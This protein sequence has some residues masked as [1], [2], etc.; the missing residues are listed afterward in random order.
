MRFFL[1][2]RKSEFDVNNC[3]KIVLVQT[4]ENLFPVESP[5]SSHVAHAQ[6]ALLACL[7][8][9]LLRLLSAGKGLLEDERQRA[10]SSR[11]LGVPRAF[12]YAREEGV[13]G[14]LDS[15]TSLPPATVKSQGAQRRRRHGR[16]ANE[17]RMTG[18]EENCKSQHAVR[19]AAPAEA[20]RA[21]EPGVGPDAAG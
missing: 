9:V 16:G 14:L 11:T 19:S 15:S 5:P 1:Y 20:G 6:C 21:L 13:I 8:L 17:E 12:G 3:A 4:L 10:G 2:C 18:E 7:A